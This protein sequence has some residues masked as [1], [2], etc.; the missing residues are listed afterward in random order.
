M[1]FNNV[2]DKKIK[3]I[4]KKSSLEGIKMIAKKDFSGFDFDKFTKDDCQFMISATQEHKEYDSIL[5][6]VFLVA[7][8]KGYVEIVAQ[9]T[10]YGVSEN[11]RDGYGNTLLTLATRN[12]NKEVVDSLIDQGAIVDL[13]D[14]EGKTALMLASALGYKEI[15]SN[16]IA[17]GADVNEKSKS[18]CPGPNDEPI[19]ALSLAQA[20]GHTELVDMLEKAGAIK[21]NRFSLR[22]VVQEEPTGLENQIKIAPNPNISLIDKARDFLSGDKTIPTGGN[23]PS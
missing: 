8:E 17:A 16:I 15:A 20:K 18:I 14:G 21:Q 4:F 12:N 1:I 19:T 10:H 2:Y 9:A 11:T 5:K 13:K 22:D 23:K 6:N 3:E 7:A